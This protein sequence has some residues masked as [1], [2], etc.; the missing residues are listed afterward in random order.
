MKCMSAHAPD[1][2]FTNLTACGRNLLIS[3]LVRSFLTPE[4]FSWWQQFKECVERVGGVPDD[5]QCPAPAAAVEESL[6][7]GEGNS[8]EPLSSSNYS[9]QGFFVWHTAAGVPCRDTIHQSALHHITVESPEDADGERGLT[10]LPQ[11]V[12]SLLG[13]FHDP[14][15]VFIP[16]YVLRDLHS[17]ELDVFHSL[18]W[19]WE[20][21]ARAV[22]SGSR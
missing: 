11:E 3:L 12:Q 6:D 1:Q 22:T 14:W 20:E 16:A 9:L 17:E 8:D 7:R 13:P 18:H 21:R 19:C 15:G 10:Q 2:Q 5:V 4:L